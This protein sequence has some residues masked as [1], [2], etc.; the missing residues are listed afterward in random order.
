MYEE[1]ELVITNI[2]YKKEAEYF[3]D[4]FPDRIGSTVKLSRP[5]RLGHSRILPFVSDKDGNPKTGLI[6]TEIICYVEDRGDW[7]LFDAIEGIY[8]LEKAKLS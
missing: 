8:T 4:V 7:V 2:K 5:L 6:A 1:R 3:K